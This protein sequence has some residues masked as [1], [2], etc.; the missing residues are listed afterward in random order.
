MKLDR[1]FGVGCAVLSAVSFGTNPLFALLLY[2][3]GMTTGSV[4]FYR[5]SLATLLLGLWMLM[6]G[7]SFRL[8]RRHLPWSLFSGV[9]LALT[10]QFL[11]MSFRV[12][13]AGI[14]ATILFVYPLMVA[15]IMRFGFRERMSRK[16]WICLFAALAGVALLSHNTGGGFSFA[17]VAYALLSA[18]IY[19]VYI[20]LVRV[21]KLREL[22]S[23]ALT[24][25]AM[26]F[27]VPIFLAILRGGADLQV[28]PDLVSWICV[29]GL[30]LFP[31]LLSFLLLAVAI[32]RIGATETSMF[33]ACEPATSIVIGV[34]V[35]GEVLTA[36]VVFGMAAILLAVTLAAV[37]A[38]SA[39][40]G[41]EK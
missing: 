37:D 40:D 31:A 13:D 10:C 27:S 34:L 21:S 1:A 25:Y 14:A 29:F 32:Q 20:V 22:D 8:E 35:F 11:F 2:R 33:G 4:L 3:R 16:V 15:L 18:L 39:D 41:G 19:A 9:L 5:L 36:R 26:L 38:K 28:P 24:F 12:M 23:G 17:G 7:K 6:C 30:A